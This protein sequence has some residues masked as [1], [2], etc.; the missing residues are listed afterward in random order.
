MENHR[1]DSSLFTVTLTL[2]RDVAV[3]T[4]QISQ[5]HKNKLSD[6]QNGPS[7]WAD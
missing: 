4:N 6:F 2:P 7:E 5:K 3:L 1:F